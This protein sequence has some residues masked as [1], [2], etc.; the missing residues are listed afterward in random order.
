MGTPQASSQRR[1][2]RDSLVAMPKPSLGVGP[3]VPVAVRVSEATAARLP[4]LA[5]AIGVSAWL[6]EIIEGR[7]R[8]G[9]LGATRSPYDAGYEEGWRAGWAAAN[10]QFREALRRVL[11]SPTPVKR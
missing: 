4:A 5:G 9:N 8:D 7:A 6:R 11:G 3:T 1:A 2:K 10:E